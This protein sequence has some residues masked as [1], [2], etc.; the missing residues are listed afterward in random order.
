VAGNY[1]VLQIEALDTESSEEWYVPQL[2]HTAFLGKNLFDDE[3]MA[4]RAAL[5]KALSA[6]HDIEMRIERLSEKIQKL[7]GKKER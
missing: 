1:D 2:G 3:E 7:Y 6:Q 4:L 5:E